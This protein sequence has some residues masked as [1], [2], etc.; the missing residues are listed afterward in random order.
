MNRITIS[1]LVRQGNKQRI[2]EWMPFELVCDGEV[3]GYCYPDVMDKHHD[4]RHRNKANTMSDKLKELPLSKK[5]QASGMMGS[6][7][8]GC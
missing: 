5:K 3:I 4:V 8:L 1:Q 7:L 6:A 2:I